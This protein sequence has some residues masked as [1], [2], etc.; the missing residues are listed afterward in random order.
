[1]ASAST[2]SNE[3]QLRE[4]P[5]TWQ[6]VKFFLSA[7]PKLPLVVR[8]TLLHV[9][10]RSEPA[11]YLDLRSELTVA[12]LRSFLQPTKPR[13]ISST[14][15]LVVR[16]QGI[17]GRIWVANYAA[18]A[19]PDPDVLDVL[20][21]AIEGLHDTSSPPVEIPRPRITAVEA[22]WTG[23]RANATGDARLPPLS[24][25]ELFDEMQ[26]E[27]SSPVTVLYLHGGAYYVGDPCT[28]RAVT[29]KL[30]KITGGRC[31]SVRYRLA[32]QNPFP[33]ALLD[34]LV[35]Y[36]ALLYPPPDAYHTPVA[37]EHVVIAGDSAGGNLSL[38]LLQTIL[39]LRRQGRQI[40][41]FGADYEIPLPAGAAV[42][43]P[44]MDITVSSPSWQAN[45]AFDYLPP[46]SKYHD[47][48]YPPCGA[49]PANPPRRHLY[50]ADGLVAH[51]L[52]TL[53]MARDW[54]GAPPVY[55]CTGWEL[56]ADED[57]SAARTLHSQ[58]VRVVFEEYEAM[59][60][61]FAMVLPQS[62]NAR[63]CFDAWAG[64]IKDL[65]VKG[66]EAVESKAVMIKA[67]TSEE[68][69]LD[70]SSLGCDAEEMRGRVL[71]HLSDA[72]DVPPEIMAKL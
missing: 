41:W 24:A 37:P 31:Y 61:C 64:F 50:V 29:K 44:W 1:M 9:L 11:K 36:M 6:N 12:V 53:V 55:L 13:S 15:R 20:V 23:Y 22:E 49:W 34:A 66:A 69:V 35:S 59:P 54:T 25:R 58:G 10:G 21:A 28:H 7:V 67:R 71:A 33:A 27:V 51:P 4:P 39:E 26:K 68:V 56:L 63:R 57:K 32:P 40:R 38:A 65:V 18:P 62:P 43:S 72:R 48:K 46:A 42:C 60:H 52:V 2:T 5:T 3:A 70:F 30:A 14:Q 16:D 47:I 17:K 19:P 8:V 45:Q